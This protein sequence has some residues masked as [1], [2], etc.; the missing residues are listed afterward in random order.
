M[1]AGEKL[2]SEKVQG[3]E[4]FLYLLAPCA[5]KWSFS[6]HQIHRARWKNATKRLPPCRNLL[7]TLVPLNFA[8]LTQGIHFMKCSIFSSLRMVF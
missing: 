6:S 1:Y 3:D 2:L 5:K 7:F 8:G 4:S